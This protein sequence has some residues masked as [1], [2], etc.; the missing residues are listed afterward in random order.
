MMISM[1]SFQ[2]TLA[3]LFVL[4]IPVQSFARDRHRS[5]NVG[6]AIISD[7]R[8][9][10]RQFNAASERGNAD[11]RYVIARDDERY[12]IRVSNPSNERI[13]VVIAV[14]GRN[15]IS[16]KKSHL[17]SHERMYILGPYQTQEY[18]GWRTGRN[19]TNRFYFTGMSDSY[20]TP[21]GD[22]TAMGVVAVAVFNERYQKIHKK[23]HR[24]N[25]RAGEKR[26]RGSSNSYSQREAP[27]TGFGEGGWSPSR[28]VHFVAQKRP[29]HKTF[30]KYEWRKTLCNIG[31]VQCKPRHANRGQNH[32]R[33]WPDDR[34]HNNRNN[35]FAPLPF[36]LVPPI[37]W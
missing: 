30:I 35:G 27:G 32:N 36:W 33:F 18:E 1:I 13:G 6:V 28:E 9:S 22:H 24:R 4:I 26:G 8:G 21:W 10:L 34:P 5:S 20:A 2:R 17:K 7:Q 12:R 25:D 16:G 37:L 19:R 14:D 23:E 11:R 31:V 15:V 29:S 3:I